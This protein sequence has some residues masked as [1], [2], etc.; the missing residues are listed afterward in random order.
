MQLN[1]RGWIPLGLGAGRTAERHRKVP[2]LTAVVFFVCCLI[3]TVF[4]LAVCLFFHAEF[5]QT[6]NESLA[7]RY[8]SV[9]RLWHGKR[10]AVWLPQG[11]LTSDIQHLIFWSL[12][13]LA[14]LSVED[15]RSRLNGF[16]VGTLAVNSFAIAALFLSATLDFLLRRSDRFLLAV[17]TL[18]PIY[19]TVTLG[20]FWFVAPDYLAMNVMLVSLSLYLFQGPGEARKGTGDCAG[21]QWQGCSL[22]SR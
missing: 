18:V 10:R 15:L 6:S 21:Q 22:A 16:A 4:P 19:G 1:L 11:F 9:A 5:L 14:G 17:V 3:L 7:Y 2:R 20:F 13:R 8:F 12:D